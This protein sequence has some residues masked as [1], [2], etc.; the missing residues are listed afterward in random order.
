MPRVLPYVL[1]LVGGVA[2]VLMC[3]G[4]SS[5]ERPTIDV[6][7]G[8]EASQFFVELSLAHAA[9]DFYGALDFYSNAAAIDMSRAELSGEVAVSDRL[10][11]NS[12]D[13]DHDVLAVHLDAN[14]A[15]NLVRWTSNNELGVVVSSL[16]EGIIDHQTVYDLGG[17]LARGLRATPG[18]VSRY[19]DFYAAYSEAVTTG[20]ADD[21]ARLYATDALIHDS[22]LGIESIGID[23]IIAQRSRRMWKDIAATSVHN[24][25]DAAVYPGPAE[26]GQDPNRAVGIYLATNNEGCVHQVAVQWI[27][28]D[29]LIE[30][31]RWFHDIETY[32]RCVPENKPSGW[33]TE[34][35]LPQM[36]DSVLTSVLHTSNDQAISQ[37]NGTEP[38]QLL[39]GNAIVRFTDAGMA[40]PV[41]GSVT[42]E[43]SRSCARRTGRVIDAD[44]QRRVFICIF[45]SDLCPNSETCDRPSSSVRF[46]ALHELGHTWMLDHVTGE[47]QTQLLE[48]SDR[49]TWQGTEVPWADR[50]VEY[51]ADVIAWGLI[52]GPI[53]M[54]R[55][56]RPG[57][58]ELSAAFRLLTMVKPL[59]SDTECTDP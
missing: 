16:N 28:D 39:I 8:S 5:A 43:P 1:R 32:S 53:D 10:R 3:T 22:L 52:E 49:A 45:E 54:V 26:Y 14:G 25:Q 18:V 51:A 42:F 59:R 21:V 30:D 56:G 4:C 35:G 9:D 47:T 15:L 55:I 58:D 7:W 40:E 50:G 24:S 17:T 37:Y 57:C 41:V 34:L 36:R 38:L 29:G 46:A 44:G 48:L 19:E 33:W 20:S 23:A 31:E 13:L 12:G 6:N 27:M 11:W 2:F